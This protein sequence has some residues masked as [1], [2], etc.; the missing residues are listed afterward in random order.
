[1]NKN[2]LQKLIALF[3]PFLVQSSLSADTKYET[4]TFAGGCFWCM[5]HPFDELEGVIDVKAG[6]TGG[7]KKNPTYEDVCTG[8]TGHAE[9]VQ[10]TFDPKKISYSELLDVFWEQINPTDSGGQF[11]DRGSQYRTGIFYHNKAQKKEAEK[12][13]QRM[14]KSGLFKNPIITEIKKAGEFYKAE[15]YHQDYYKNYSCEYNFYRERSGRE[16]YLKGLWSKEDQKMK[17]AD[18]KY[19]KTDSEQIKKKLTPLQYEVTQENGTERPFQNEYW[20]NK[21]EGIYVDI[22]SGEPLFSS[23]DKFDS[24]TGWPSFTKPLRSE[25]ITKKEDSSLF[26]KR[27]EV[28][29][30]KGDSHLGHVFDDGPQPAGLRYCINS[31]SLRF[32]PRKDLVKEG[33]GEYLK[34]FEK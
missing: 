28:R 22:V 21:E 3:I 34:L 1:M 2:K 19:K 14:Q 24:G 6:Y 15:D 9:A 29:S 12:S 30:R 23:R 16:Q 27:V 11:A 25:N 5:E 33:Y 26:M 4:A 32:I 7:H 13:K 20:N 18:S 10:I 8:T 31:A 17:P